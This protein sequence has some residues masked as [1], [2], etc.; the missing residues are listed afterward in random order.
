MDN[1]I[2][3]D[4]GR[5]AQDLQIRRVASGERRPAPGRGEHRSLHHALPQG[6]D[7][8]PQ[9]GGD[10][11]D[12][13]SRPAAARAGR[14]ERDDPQGDRG[15]GQAHPDLAAA[16]RAADNPKRLEDL[17]LPFKPKK[18]TKASDA[19]EQG[20]RAAGVP[21]LDSRRD[22]H[23]LAR[24]G[25]GIR[26]RREGPRIGREG[27]GRRRPHPGRGHQRDGRRSA[28]RIRK[29]VWKTGKIVTDQGRGPRGPGPRIS[30]LFRLFR[31]ASRR[32]RRIACWRSIAATRKAR[33]RSGSTSP[34]PTSRPRSSPAPARR[35]SSRRALPRRRDRRARPPDPSQHGARGPPRSDRGR[36]E[37]RRRG[38]RQEPAQP[39]APAADPQAGR[40][41]HRPRVPDRLQGGRARPRRQPA[42]PGA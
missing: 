9:R 32:S 20:P 36:R 13:A 23:R 8:Q 6:T 19:R 14:A 27:P 30:R 31:A 26:Q 38:L 4:L 16:I 42:R 34:G 11:R 15:A 18:R 7:R 41:G 35:P 29:V 22:A 21:D 33:S 1:P 12:P 40:D 37:A 10:P 2:Q 5:I 28:T 24:R 3:V 17:Y 25:P 39:A